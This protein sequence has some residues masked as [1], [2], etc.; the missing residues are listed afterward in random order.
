MRRIFCLYNVKVNGECT[1]CQPDDDSLVIELMD[2][3]KDITSAVKRDGLLKCKRTNAACVLIFAHYKRSELSGNNSFRVSSA[4]DL[5]SVLFR[6]H[7]TRFPSKDGP[8]THRAQRGLH[9][10]HR[11]R[12]ARELPRLPEALYLLLPGARLSGFLQRAP[13]LGGAPGTVGTFPRTAELTRM[14]GPF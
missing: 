3:P 6:C 1:K 13:L 5:S 12:A 8:Q 7:R 11:V 2:S 14:S 9:Q 4:N 10:S